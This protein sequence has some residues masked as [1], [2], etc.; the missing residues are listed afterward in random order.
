MFFLFLKSIGG[1]FLLEIG[2]VEGVQRMFDSSLEEF[3]DKFFRPIEDQLIFQ[4]FF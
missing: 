2:V 1:F 3:V 4:V